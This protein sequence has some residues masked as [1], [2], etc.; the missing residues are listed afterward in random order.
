[1]NTIEANH[2]P[3]SQRLAFL[4]SKLGTE[5]MDFE[6]LVFHYMGKFCE[7]YNGGYWQFY[8]LSNGGFYIALDTTSRLHICNPENCTDEEMGAEAA[9]IGVCIYALNALAWQRQ[10]EIAMEAYHQ[11]R[12]YASCN[13]ESAAIFRFID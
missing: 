13:P 3:E 8:G 2:I 10:S 7:D 12:D 5:C 1:M 9:S 4:P 11:L 6:K